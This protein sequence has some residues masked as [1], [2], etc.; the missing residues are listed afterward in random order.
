MATLEDIT[1][2][3]VWVFLP[4]LPV[5]HAVGLVAHCPRSA[6]LRHILL[7][8]FRGGNNHTIFQAIAWVSARISDCGI[9]SAC[10][11]SCMP[12]ACYKCA[13]PVQPLARTPHTV[14][15]AHSLD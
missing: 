12:I 9:T 10:L 7:Y 2:A 6:K 8:P 11:V 15:A 5:T 13:T 1:F 14:C 3:A 4:L